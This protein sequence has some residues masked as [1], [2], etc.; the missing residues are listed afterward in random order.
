MEHFRVDPKWN[1]ELGALEKFVGTRDKECF[2]RF[3]LPFNI[4]T[5]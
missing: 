1:L 5:S 2:A 3:G 4:N